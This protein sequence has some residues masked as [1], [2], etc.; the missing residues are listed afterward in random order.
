MSETPRHK[1]DHSDQ[2]LELYYDGKSF[3]NAGKHQEAIELLTRSW[4]H[5][6]HAHT[7]F[8]LAMAYKGCNSD[9]KYLEWIRNAYQLNA[10]HSMIATEYANAL[11]SSGN[12]IE[13]ISVLSLALQRSPNY[14]PARSL[15]S[16]IRE[17][18]N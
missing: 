8:C 11:S 18:T 6:P 2:A 12:Q 16:R 1:S 3:Y 14:G 4:N 15:L 9:V 7:A 13:A 17:L 5:R 10:N